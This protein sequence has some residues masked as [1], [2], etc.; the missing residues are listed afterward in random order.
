MGANPDVATARAQC[1]V[2]AGFPLR[3]ARRIVRWVTM[4]KK[5]IEDYEKQMSGK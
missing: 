5:M 1:T 2:A 4:C 3:V